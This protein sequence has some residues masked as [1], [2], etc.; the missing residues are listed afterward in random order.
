MKEFIP[1]DLLRLN[2]FFANLQLFWEVRWVC[3][4]LYMLVR[5]WFRMSYGRRR[6]GHFE[7]STLFVQLAVSVRLQSKPIEFRGSVLDVLTNCPLQVVSYVARRINIVAFNETQ[8]EA[9]NLIPHGTQIL[10]EK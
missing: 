1:I 3:N 9:E 10:D 4:Q 7:N 8:G 6:S 2:A 5:F